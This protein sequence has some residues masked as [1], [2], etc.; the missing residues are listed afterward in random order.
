[1]WGKFCTGV[2]VVWNVFLMLLG[3]A[4]WTVL[5]VGIVIVAALVVGGC[6]E[7]LRAIESSESAYRIL[8]IV[9]LGAIL[10]IGYIVGMEVRK[11]FVRR[12]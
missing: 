9:G 5:G 3:R 4:L 2:K 10:V 6:S 11:F 7:L 8:E 1:M 12:G